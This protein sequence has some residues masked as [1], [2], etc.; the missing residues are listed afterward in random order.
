MF[1]FDN[2]KR[3]RPHIHAQYG[4]YEALIAIDDGDVLGGQLPK[5]KMMLVLAWVEIH[6]GRVNGRLA[7]GG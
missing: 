2:K 7:I 3:H 5:S 6:Q 4:E 1:H